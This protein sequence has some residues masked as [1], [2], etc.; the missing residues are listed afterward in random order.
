VQNIFLEKGQ[1][2]ERRGREM[3][4]GREKDRWLV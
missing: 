3:N 4:K 1:D 2:A